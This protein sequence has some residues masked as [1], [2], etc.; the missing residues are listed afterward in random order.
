MYVPSYQ[1]HNVLNVYSKQLRNNMVSGKKEKG[2]DRLPADQVKLTPEAKR[3]ATIEKV[4]KEIVDKITR[5]GSG[6]NTRDKFTEQAKGEPQK[7][8]SVT[9]TS[10]ATFVFNVIDAI[11]KKITNKL[12][13]EGSSF[14]VQR[15]EQLSKEDGDNKTESWA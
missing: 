13:V 10:E 8:T 14:L 2:P 3:Q 12:S 1:M 9:E 11:N 15:I 4:S 5:F 7:E 6:D